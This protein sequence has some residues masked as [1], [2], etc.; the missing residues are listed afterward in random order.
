MMLSGFFVDLDKVVPV[1]WPF[2]WISSLKYAFTIQLRNEFED[3]EDIKIC[4]AF[5]DEVN[6]LYGNDLIKNLNVTLRMD[7]SFICLVRIYVLFLI[8]ALI[9]LVITTRRV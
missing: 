4:T 5:G 2:Q 9:G 8:I 3:N 1:L 6:C 7:V